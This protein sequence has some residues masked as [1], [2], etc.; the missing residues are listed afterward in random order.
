[1]T[2]MGDA[3]EGNLDI[4]AEIDLMELEPFDLLS[5]QL[6]CMHPQASRAELL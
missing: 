1:M 3:F 5:S 2:E 4:V 6:F